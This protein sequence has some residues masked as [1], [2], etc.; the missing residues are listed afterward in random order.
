MDKTSLGGK[1]R[2]AQVLQQNLSPVVSEELLRTVRLPPGVSLV[3]TPATPSPAPGPAPVVPVA[4]GSNPFDSLPYPMAGDR[5]KADDFKK[6]SQALKI[7]SDMTVL[8]GSLFGRTF[9]DAKLAVTG[10][11]Y[12]IFRVMSVFGAE[13]DNLGDAS[14]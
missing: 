7:I 3:P 5:I 4:P 12:Q 8:S 6:L 2:V 13:I 10:Q 11:G 9:A 14:L 1:S